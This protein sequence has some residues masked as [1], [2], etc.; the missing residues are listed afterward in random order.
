MIVAAALIPVAAMIGGGVDVSR[1]YLAKGRLQSACDAAALAAR[2]VMKYDQLTDEV[3][4]TGREFFDFNFPRDVYGTAAFE[5]SITRPETGVVRINASTRLP[6][7]LMRL[8]GINEMP[9]SV[10][11]DASLNFVNTDVVL[12]L[13]VTGSM[14][15]PLDGEPKIKALREAVIALYEELEPVQK[16]LESQGLRLRYGIVPYSSTVNVGRLISDVEPG[17]IRSTSSYPSRVANYYQ[18][19]YL[20]NS[21]TSSAAWEYY[22]GSSGTGASS[23][24]SATLTSSSCQSWVNSSTTSSGSAPS[25]TYQYSYDGS[26]TSSTYVQ[27]SDWGWSGAPVTSGTYRSCRR[28]KITTTTTYVTRRGFSNWTYRHET[29]DLSQYKERGGTMILASSANGTVPDPGGSFNAQQLAAAGSGVS[30]TSVSWNGCIEERDTTSAIAGGTSMAI[31]ADAYDLDINMIP[32]SDAT[33][34]RPMVPD[35]VYTRNAGSTS[36]N[37]SAGSTSTTGWIKNYTYSQG[38]WACP[39]EAHR[40]DEWTHDDMNTYVA[41]LQTVGGTYHD[42]GMLWGARMISTGGIFADGCEEYNGMPC[43]RHIIFMTDGAQTAYCNV[44]TAYG[45]EQNDLR[46][47]GSGSCPN[48]LARHEQRFRML[49]NAVK[50]MNVSV[51]VIGFDTSLN[52]NLTGCASNSNQATSLADRE[53]LIARFRQIG[54][55]IGALRLTK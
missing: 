8:F 43:N 45:V 40:L 5:P 29:Y 24:S 49:C 42:I 48:Q 18:A 23:P 3:K 31:P 9:I 55:Q 32:S 35:V 12:V 30:T 25:P 20:S 10:S 46:V 19:V 51:W 28:W 33:R 54:N 37:S 4:N 2:R 17:Y 21:P 38:Y 14:A 22:N 36:V 44:L 27:S 1:A 41:G 6:T 39:T 7:V 53:S 13:D 50:N 34:W 26:S 15:D 16:Q 11:C 47:T 52:A